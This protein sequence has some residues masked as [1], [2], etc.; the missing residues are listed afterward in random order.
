VPPAHR[1]DARTTGLSTGSSK[2]FSE[3]P[4]GVRH[5]APAGA[6]GEGMTRAHGSVPWWGVLTSALAPVAL[7][8]GWT[9]AAGRRTDGYDPGVDTIS[10]LAAVGA[11]DRWVMT[12]A[13]A[14]LGVCH[15]GTAVALRTAAA[16]GR[17]VLAAGGL[18]TVGVAL[19]PLPTAGG[20]P[21][22]TA[23][24]A[25]AFGALA[26]W[27]ALAAVGGAERHDAVPAALRP[28]V[29]VPA[30]LAL[31]GLVAWFAVEL[32]VDGRVGLAERVAAGAQALW[33]LAVVLSGRVR[34]G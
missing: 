25:A 4:D 13:L 18:A 23:T 10:A 21:A 14:V 34:A 27:P 12:S 24:A 2:N 33:P 1:A 19:A 8:G 29:A 11:P 5:R 16:P 9:V 32:A 20:S 31:G 30:G 26:L 6:Y 28:P 3:R 22:H 17:L 7:I 15:L